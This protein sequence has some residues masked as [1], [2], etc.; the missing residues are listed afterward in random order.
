M[1]D[2]GV[3]DGGQYVLRLQEDPVAYEEFLTSHD[4]G[5]GG[6]LPQ[7]VER[8]VDALCTLLIRIVKGS[9][10]T[11]DLAIDS[12]EIGAFRKRGG[13]GMEKH[14]AEGGE[15]EKSPG[16]L[17]KSKSSKKLS[18]AAAEEAVLLAVL[19]PRSKK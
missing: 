5:W 17:R 6:P 8:S 1:A 2:F 16:G 10:D 13:G 9:K 14:K 11:L 3:R 15:G 4:P 19:T 7:P 18:L 12:K